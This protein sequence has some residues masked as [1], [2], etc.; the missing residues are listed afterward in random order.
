MSILIKLGNCAL[1]PCFHQIFEP[2]ARCDYACWN[3]SD[4]K[5]VDISWYY[6]TYLIA[7]LKFDGWGNLNK[8]N[9][10]CSTLKIVWAE[11]FVKTPQMK[12]GVMEDLS[13]PN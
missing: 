7:S 8:A 13:N 9:P 3:I 11:V 12:V 10:T 5:F 1:F 6:T 4:G 2:D